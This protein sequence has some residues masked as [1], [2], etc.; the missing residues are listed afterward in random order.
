MKRID[1]GHELKALIYAIGRHEIK[2]ASEGTTT[3]RRTL[4][5]RKQRFHIETRYYRSKQRVLITQQSSGIQRTWSF[6]EGRV[7][8]ADGTSVSFSSIP[9]KDHYMRV[10]RLMSRH[11]SKDQVGS[12]LAFKLDYILK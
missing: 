6:D 1:W 11:Y 9:V 5:H 2:L 12:I 3:V 8:C 7:V 4:I 10:E